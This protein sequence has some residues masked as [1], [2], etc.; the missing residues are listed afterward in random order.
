[1]QPGKV[2]EGIAPLILGSVS[3]ESIQDSS[4]I[5]IFA[6]INGQISHFVFNG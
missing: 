2:P 3:A 6:D 5:L 1:M 4:E